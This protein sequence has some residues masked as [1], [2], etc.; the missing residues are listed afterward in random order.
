MKQNH[1]SFIFSYVNNI[2]SFFSS[3]KKA[4]VFEKTRVSCYK[5][6]DE[7]KSIKLQMWCKKIKLS[8]LL[9]KRINEFKMN[10]IQHKIPQ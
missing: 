8:R 4:N 5:L 6:C 7:N 10:D 9:A 1:S 2:F 3:R